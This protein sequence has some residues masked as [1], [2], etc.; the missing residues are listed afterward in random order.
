MCLL[1]AAILLHEFHKKDKQDGSS[2]YTDDD[3]NN[4]KSSSEQ[5]YDNNIPIPHSDLSDYLIVHTS[6]KIA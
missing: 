6:N 1:F 4:H 5:A 3:R 2:S